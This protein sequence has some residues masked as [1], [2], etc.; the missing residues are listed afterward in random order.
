M[1]ITEEDLKK[2]FEPHQNSEPNGEE[3]I[4][5]K[6]KPTNEIRNIR[7]TLRRIHQ[8]P[9]QSKT[10]F[11]EIF[12]SILRFLA[13]SGFAGFLIFLGLGWGGISKQLEWGYFVSYLNEAVPTATPTARPPVAATRTPIENLAI[14][15]QL[16]NLYAPTDLGTSANFP[17]NTLKIEKINL[18]APV[19]WN[20]DE[21]QILE[22]LKDGVAHYK[23]TSRPGEGGNIF[24]VGHSSNYFWI[25]SDYNN[26]FALLDKLQPGDRI[27][28]SYL[29]KKYVYEVKITNIVKPDEIQVLENTPKETLSLMTCWPI[30]TSLKRMIVQSELLYTENN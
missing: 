15:N 9:K 5:K 17:L 12:N 30:G 10:S 8:N 29:N 4:V 21:D 2:L 11:G 27:E 6:K 25:Q 19:L 7:K 18:S 13:I 1:K 3:L 28:L 14:P 23:D 16:P 20:I 24:I 26:I 22:N